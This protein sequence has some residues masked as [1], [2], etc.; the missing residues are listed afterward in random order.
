M[1]RTTIA[2][3]L[4]TLATASHAQTYPTKPIR[5]IV[6]YTPGGTADML[7][8]AVGQ[9]LTEAWG[10]QVVVENRPGAGTNIGTEVAAKAAPDGYTL[11]M[12]TVA[13]AINPTLYPKLNFDILRDF[14]HITNFA[15]V[16]GIVV[17]HPS[18]PA[19]NVKEL[20]ALAR[21]NPNALRHGS[22]GIGS[23]H[24]LAGE[25]FKSMSGVKM[26]HVPYRGASPAL[27]D[28]VAGHI[29]VY[30]GAMVSTL[31]HVKSG[32]VRAL[33]VTTLKRV[34][35][36]P[37]I[38]TISEQGLKGF[39]TGSWFGVSVPTGTSKEIVNRLHKESVRILAL[40]EVRDRMI[41]EG[42]EFVG[43][44]PEQF[45]A[46]LKGEIEKWGKAVKASGARSE[47]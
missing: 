28:I 40:P 47:G 42:A 14:V 27:V 11:F 29:E 18:V 20:I 19:K 23:P 4:F 34:A 15:K 13:N 43:D 33:G 17:V 41:A 37:D 1:R 6:G 30:F 10:Q 38:P 22:T 21:A 32:R 39:E 16:P 26:V 2:V 44:T 36:V 9:K 7:A 35:A 45:T 46:F 24:H 12:P 3:A 5:W 8:R 25:I 31:P